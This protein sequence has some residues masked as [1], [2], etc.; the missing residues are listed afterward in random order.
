MRRLILP[1]LMLPLLSG[2]VAS[3]I[4]STAVSIATLPVKAASAG[5]D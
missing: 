5:V 1:L 3:A 4:A 2:C